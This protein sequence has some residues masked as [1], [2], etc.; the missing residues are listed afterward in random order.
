MLK[1]TDRSNALTVLPPDSGCP[2]AALRT[3]LRRVGLRPTRQRLS[4]GWLLFAHGDRHVTAEMLYDEAIS[5]KVL[6]SLA[7]VYNTLRQFTDA[8]LLRQ[9][10]F[11]GT[12]A[13]FDTNT[14]EHHHFYLDEEDRVIDMPDFN[15]VMNSI[16]M[17]PEGMEVQQ[18]EIIV[19][20]KKRQ[21]LPKLQS[22]QSI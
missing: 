6:I 21:A 8:G 15:V 13:Y 4:L 9:L 11:D 17:P 18:I 22:R 16:P 14:S 5:A 1:P 7:T 10:S 2:L 12:K 3:R 20:L 19:R